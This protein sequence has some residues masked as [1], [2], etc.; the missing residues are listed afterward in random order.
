MENAVARDTVIVLP[1]V[2]Q[3]SPV[4][5]AIVKAPVSVLSEFT[6][7]IA[8]AACV[9]V[10]PFGLVVT[11]HIC[12]ASP[13]VPDALFTVANVATWLPLPDGV[14]TSPVS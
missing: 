10:K 12:V 3:L 8:I 14:V 5:Q 13:Q 11:W 6:P 2:T 9:V 7:P 1:P 4:P